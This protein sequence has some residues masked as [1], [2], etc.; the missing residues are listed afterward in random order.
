[1]EKNKSKKKKETKIKT[2][3]QLE[4]QWKNSGDSIGLLR[5]PAAL[6]G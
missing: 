3:E 1:M 2:K 5:F 4:K 6:A